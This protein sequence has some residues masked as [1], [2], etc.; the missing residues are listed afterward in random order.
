MLHS[1]THTL[2]VFLNIFS[3]SL[4]LSLYLSVPFYLSCHFI[5]FSITPFLSLFLSLSLTHTHTLHSLLPFLSL[6][7]FLRIY[8]RPFSFCYLRLHINSFIQFLFVRRKINF[9]CIYCQTFNLKEPKCEL[10]F[11]RNFLIP[12]SFFAI[13]K[14]YL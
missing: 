13:K 11:C 4:I 2:S 1:K 8:F 10:S 14:N 3:L 6:S 9:H 12:K 5:L 7:L